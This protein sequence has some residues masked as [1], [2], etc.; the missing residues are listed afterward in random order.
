MAGLLLSRGFA[1]AF[2]DRLTAAARD[3]GI[4][5][6]FVHLPDDPAMRLPDAA[7]AGKTRWSHGEAMVNE[8]TV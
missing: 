7:C 1:A 5:V 3:A 6:E 4:A 2:G 8:R